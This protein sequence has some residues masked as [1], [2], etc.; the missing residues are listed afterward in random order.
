MKRKILIITPKVMIEIIVLLEAVVVA[1]TS[2]NCLEDED[3]N[4]TTYSKHVVT[5]AIDLCTLLK[6]VNHQL[7][8]ERK[9][10]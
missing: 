4:A 3:N 2:N 9:G 5:K 6:I 8:F 7:I 1:D 10:R